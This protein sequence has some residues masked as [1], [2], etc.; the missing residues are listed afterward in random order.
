MPGF[1]ID[2]FGLGPFGLGTPATA[3]DP[4]SGQAGSRYLNPQTKD[5]ELDATTG[6]LAQMPATRQR[7]LLALMTKLKSATTAQKFGASMPTKM[8]TTFEAEVQQAVRL[9]LFH[10]TDTE[11]VIRIDGILVE[12]G[13]GSRA[14]VTVS[15][16]DIVNGESDNV[17]APL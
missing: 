14:R 1:G 4:P 8:G 6:Q 7:V 16:T 17:E 15:Y 11:P 3:P 9:A 10:L 5:Y 13:R 2:S 12:R